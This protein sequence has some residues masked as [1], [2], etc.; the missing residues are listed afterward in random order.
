MPDDII[1]KLGTAGIT[2]LALFA[3]LCGNDDGSRTFLERPGMDIKATDLVTSVQQATIVAAWSTIEV[4]TSV[5]RS[6][7]NLPPEVSVEEMDQ[8]AKVFAGSA[9]GFELSPITTPSKTFC[10]R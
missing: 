1:E 6:M 8:H 2:S 4:E 9:D 7:A 3:F 10:L 5:K